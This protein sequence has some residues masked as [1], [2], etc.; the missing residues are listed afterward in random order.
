MIDGYEIELDSAVAL[1][2]I[3]PQNVTAFTVE[4]GLPIDA[5]DLWLDAL[6]GSYCSV[7]Q[8]PDTGNGTLQCGIYTPPTV[9][10]LPYDYG[11]YGVSHANLER[12]CNEYLKLG[13]QG[14]SIFFA[15]GDNAVGEF[16]IGPTGCKGNE[17]RVFGPSFPAS[18]PYVYAL[19]DNHL[20]S[21][22]DSSP[23]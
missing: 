6:D 22:A 20:S 23:L 11:E 12:Q 7:K 16:P 19:M 9:L 4:T 17:S 3:Y 15:S 21:A 8:E 10:A 1:P 5:L 2:I 18:C 13:L 14:H